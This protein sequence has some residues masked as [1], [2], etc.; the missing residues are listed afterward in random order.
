MVTAGWRPASV[1]VGDIFGHLLSLPATGVEGVKGTRGQCRQRWT[2]G[3][4]DRLP[5]PRPDKPEPT[6]QRR[7][8]EL[9]VNDFLSRRRA[10]EDRRG[11]DRGCRGIGTLAWQGRD[12]GDPGRAVLASRT[13]ASGLP[14]AL[15]ERIYV[16]FPPPGQLEL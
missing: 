8:F 1:P 4:R 5:D 6:R 3:N 12:R 14:G 7:R 11:H 13:G 15:S 2:A 16:P 9:P 10:A